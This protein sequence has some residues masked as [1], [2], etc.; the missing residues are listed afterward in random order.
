MREEPMLTVYKEVTFDSGHYL[1]N[2]KGPC[3][4]MHG[5]TYKLIVGVTRTDSENFL[6][7]TGM[8][9]DFK[10]LSAIIDKEVGFLDHQ[11][12]NNF[13]PQPTAENTILYLVEHIQDSLPPG[14]KVVEA[15]LWETPTSCCKWTA[16]KGG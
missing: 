5:H 8:L 13:I 14:V 7:S 9:I 1:V 2:Y 3:A 12:L 4:N 15:T 11:I 10:V 6:G 16:D